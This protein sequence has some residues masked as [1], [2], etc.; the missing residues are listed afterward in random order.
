[1]VKIFSYHCQDNKKSPDYDIAQAVI[2]KESLKQMLEQNNIN[3][4]QA[5]QISTALVLGVI[6]FA[7][8][9]LWFRTNGRMDREV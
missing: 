3:E 9:F 4:D 8:Y 7:Q 1:M 6:T 2:K 5:K